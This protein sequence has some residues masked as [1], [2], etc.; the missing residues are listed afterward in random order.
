[1]NN[2][3]NYQ[4]LRPYIQNGDLLQWHGNY[5]FSKIIRLGTGEDDNH[6]SQAIR[7]PFFENRIFSIE[8]LS[9]GLHLWP[10]SDLL[11]RYDG[12]VTWYPLLDK[13]RGTA[14]ND[15]TRWLLT[16]LGKP[17]DWHSCVS[18]WR[19]IFGWSPKKAD[20]RRLYCSESVFL[21]WKERFKDMDSLLHIGAGLN[22]L[23]SITVSPVPGKP[24]LD[25]GI[26]MTEGK[27]LVIGGGD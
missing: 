1:M 6:S 14:A 16:H 23:K 8:A 9:S 22:Q 12:W 20:H 26:W 10:L 27:R 11:A 21:A 15:A 24:M 25:L 7:I 19:S 5:P 3:S 4:R 18:N 13:Y 2:L 17:Y